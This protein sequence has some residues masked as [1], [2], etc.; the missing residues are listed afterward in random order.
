MTIRS[1]LRM[2]AWR[3]AQLRSQATAAA[4]A[5]PEAAALAVHP[6]HSSRAVRAHS[7][8]AQAAAAASAREQRRGLEERSATHLALDAPPVVY[9]PLYSAP[10]LPPGHRFPMA[11]FA[12]IH[13]RLLAEGTVDPR[14]VHAP[15]CLPSR[16]LLCLVHSPKF[17]DAFCSGTLDEQRMRRI[18]FGEVARTQAL[19]DRTLAEVAGTILTAELALAHGLACN[20]AGGTHHAF[21]EY[22]S[23]F[24][25]LNDLA[26]TTELLL[27]QGRA[28]RVLILDLDVHQGDGTAHIFSGRQDVFTLSVHAASNFPAR[29]QASHLDIALPDGTGADRKSV[30]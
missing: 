30:V 1:S 8:I 24:C 18:G 3:L 2:G 15:A 23:G 26:L 22:G 28:S 20:T 29:K 5:V 9:H 13:S 27:L 16:V 25:I 4:A 11:I 21:R 10:Q 19:I 12:A 14:Q 7:S 6:A 17:V